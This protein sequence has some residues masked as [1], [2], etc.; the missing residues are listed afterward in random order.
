MRPFPANETQ[1]WLMNFE[2][3]QRLDRQLFAPCPSGSAVKRKRRRGT[4]TRC[5]MPQRYNTTEGLLSI[6]LRLVTT[7]VTRKIQQ[8]RVVVL[9]TDNFLSSLLLPAWEITCSGEMWR[10]LDCSCLTLH[11]NRDWRL[12]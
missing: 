8:R 10:G 1:R 6:S 3:L 11:N 5:P 12:S 4:T 7:S 9:S 2:N